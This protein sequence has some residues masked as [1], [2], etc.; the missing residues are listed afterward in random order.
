MIK[1]GALEG[2]H[3][4][5]VGGGEALKV[6][7]CRA[8]NN[9]MAGGEAAIQAAIDAGMLPLLLGLMRSA[10][11]ASLDLRR[12]ALFAVTNAACCGSLKQVCTLLRAGV[13]QQ[14]VDVVTAGH[15][16]TGEVEL[17]TLEAQE[18][19][20]RAGLELHAAGLVP[21]AKLAELLRLA[22]V[23]TFLGRT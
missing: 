13:V 3:K 7:A 19:F 9:L 5:L 4:A 12:T 17:A 14:L 23:C 6:V 2:L 8:V 15:T 22:G 1:A 20:L 11:A 16:Q 10:D 21:R 18:C